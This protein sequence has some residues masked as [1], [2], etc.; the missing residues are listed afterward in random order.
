MIEVLSD[1][2]VATVG[3]GDGEGLDYVS[4]VIDW[5]RRQLKDPRTDGTSPNDLGGV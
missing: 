1:D 2:V 3:G 4:D 5:I